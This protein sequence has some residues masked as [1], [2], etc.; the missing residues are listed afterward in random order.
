MAVSCYERFEEAA[1]MILNLDELAGLDESFA[2]FSQS[3]E[4]QEWAQRRA[5]QEEEMEE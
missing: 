5:E 4:F 3:A 2:A 1:S